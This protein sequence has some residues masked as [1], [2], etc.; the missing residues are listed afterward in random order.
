VAA[1]LTRF[2][3]LWGASPL[4]FVAGVFLPNGLSWLLQVE[5][6][7]FFLV[8]IM[9]SPIAFLVGTIGTAVTPGRRLAT[10]P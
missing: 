10:M 8:A 5:E 7:V 4:I 1:V 9:G 6:Q 2:L 3:L